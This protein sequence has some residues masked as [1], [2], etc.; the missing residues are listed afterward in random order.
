ML[1]RCRGVGC[2]GTHCTGLAVWDVGHTEVCF[3]GLK[4][5]LFPTDEPQ[6]AKF[7]CF[8]T[9]EVEMLIFL[10]TKKI[11]KEGFQSSHTKKIQEKQFTE[12]KNSFTVPKN[13]F[14]FVIYTK[15]LRMSYWS[16]ISNLDNMI[17]LQKMYL[18]VNSFHS[19]NFKEAT[20]L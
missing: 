15:P 13:F 17:R 14:F 7:V 6:W 4:H 8:Q 20:E 10:L 1:R 19:L 3:P 16:F 12:K 2:R 18:L 11:Q 9:M 5:Q